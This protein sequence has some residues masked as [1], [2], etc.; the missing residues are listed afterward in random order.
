MKEL[1]INKLT[2]RKANTT[3]NHFK[4]FC[5]LFMQSNLVNIKLAQSAMQ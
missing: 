5:G 4:D 2:Q 3:A 1:N